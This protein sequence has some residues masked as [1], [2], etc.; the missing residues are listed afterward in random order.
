MHAGFQVQNPL[1]NN[2]MMTVIVGL[3]LLSAFNIILT[4]MQPILSKSD[5]TDDAAPADTEATAR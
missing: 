3:G 4:I 5:K 2:L 1:N